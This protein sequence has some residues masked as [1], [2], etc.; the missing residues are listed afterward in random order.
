MEDVII[1]SCTTL[2]TGPCF[3]LY[4]AGP[5]KTNYGCGYGSSLVPDW[6]HPC[7]WQGSPLSSPCLWKRNL[8]CSS[9][10]IF[11]SSTTSEVG[12]ISS[13]SS[14][15]LGRSYTTKTDF[16]LQSCLG[17]GGTQVVAIFAQAMPVPG[18]L[19]DPRCRPMAIS[20]WWPCQSRESWH[21]VNGGEAKHCNFQRQTHNTTALEDC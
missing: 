11:I 6:P 2:A 7:A 20:Q 4:L 5:Q 10:M 9:I 13:P 8:Q 21:R 16:P 18:Y 1:Y 14:T 15:C 3:C 19:G 17:Y 12:V